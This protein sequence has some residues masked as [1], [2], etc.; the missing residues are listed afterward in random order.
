MVKDKFCC[1]WR[2]VCYVITFFRLNRVSSVIKY[3]FWPIVEVALLFLVCLLWSFIHLF[4]FALLKPS[5]MVTAWVLFI[6][7]FVL[8]SK[9]LATK[10]TRQ[11][12]VLMTE[13]RISVNYCEFDCLFFIIVEFNLAWRN[14]PNIKM[15]LSCKPISFCY[16]M[17]LADI[18]H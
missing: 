5:L 17:Q 1:T 12:V 14:A 6:I 3:G 4:I 16:W 2:S 15:I 11:M 9:S 7:Q 13:G 18:C 8:R 10:C